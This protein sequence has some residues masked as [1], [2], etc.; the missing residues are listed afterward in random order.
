MKTRIS[1]AVTATSFLFALSGVVVAQTPSPGFTT[2]YNF[3][4]SPDGAT[5]YNEA[6]AIGSCGEL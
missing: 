2:L 5:P 1:L 4:G 6:L 3:E